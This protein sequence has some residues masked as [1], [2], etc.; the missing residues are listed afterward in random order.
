MSL[1]P[2]ELAAL[3][4]AFGRQLAALRQGEA[5]SRFGWS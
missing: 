2:P 4:R 5:Q 1:E 3:K